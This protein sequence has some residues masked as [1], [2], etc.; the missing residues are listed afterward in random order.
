[1]SDSADA[2]KAAAQLEAALGSV[3]WRGYFE[4]ANQ[5]GDPTRAAIAVARQ[6]GQLILE[7][8]GIR[9]TA[10]EVRQNPDQSPKYL[11]MLFSADRQA[12]WDFADVAGMAHVDWLHHCEH[13]DYDAFMSQQESAG[14]QSL[15]PLSAPTCS[16]IDERIAELAHTFLTRH[17]R[18]VL[19]EQGSLTPID[20]I[21]D[22]YG[23]MLGRARVTHVRVAV[24][25]LYAAGQIDDDGKGKFW[26]RN[27]RWMS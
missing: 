11:L 17:L 2:A 16:D 18:R 14:L 24:K 6:F 22:T 27:I 4:N 1:M 26:T 10:V 25:A 5:P 8:T 13:V 3:P 7:S 9:S 23:E 15:F 20:A 21:E 19:A 12:H